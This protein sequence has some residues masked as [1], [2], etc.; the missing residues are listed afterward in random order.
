MKW[1]TLLLFS[2]TL[3]SAPYEW[4]DHRGMSMDQMIQP[5]MILSE[6]IPVT[7]DQVNQ[8]WLEERSHQRTRDNVDSFQSRLLPWKLLLLLIAISLGWFLYRLIL[9]FQ[10]SKKQEESEK[11]S[12][13]EAKKQLLDA[14]GW[15]WSAFRENPENGCTASPPFFTISETGLFDQRLLKAKKSHRYTLF[16]KGRDSRGR[17]RGI[18][19]EQRKLSVCSL[20]VNVDRTS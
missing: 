19:D 2:S 13:L 16:N 12:L 14:L 4:E 8:R 6:Q 11:Q 10:I 5:P 17:S 9:Q 15:N 3:M 20:N 1:F 18:W 7:M